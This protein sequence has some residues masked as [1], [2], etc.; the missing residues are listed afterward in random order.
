MR[1]FDVMRCDAMRYNAR[2]RAAMTR[3]EGVRLLLCTNYWHCTR[4]VNA[5]LL[6]SGLALDN[7]HGP[8]MI[9]TR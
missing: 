7:V 1:Q 6:C 5:A 2:A 9:M 4:R 8:D 3:V